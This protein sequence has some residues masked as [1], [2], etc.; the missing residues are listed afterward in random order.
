MEELQEQS[1]VS[2]AFRPLYRFYDGL[3]RLVQTRDETI[4]GAQQTVTQ[5]GYDALGRT[6]ST[7]VP[8]LASYVRG[9]VAPNWASAVQTNQAYDALGQVVRVTA[10]DG[11]HTD[12]MQA[13]LAD[14]TVDANGHFQTSF[15]DVFG[16]VTSVNETLT[17]LEDPFT[18][19]N[20]STWITNPA[21]LGCQVIDASGLKLTGSGN[22]NNTAVV[23][24]TAFN[25]DGSLQGQGVKFEFKVDGANNE[26]H[27][28]LDNNASGAAYQRVSILANSGKLTAR[29]F[30]SSTSST[31][32]DLASPL[33]ANVW[34]VG[35]LEVSSGGLA[36][37]EVWQRDAPSQHGQTSLSLA[38][39]QSYRFSATLFTGHAW[40]DNYQEFNTQTTS[41]RYDVLDHLV[42]V[43][44]ARGASTVIT[45]SLAGA[46]IGM[47][48]PNL[49]DWQY[50]YDG[51]GNLTQQVDAKNQNLCFY[52]DALNRLTGKYYNG[53][54]PTCPG[55]PSLTTG[56]SYDFGVNGKGRR[57]GLIDASGSAKWLYDSRGRVISETKTV[58][59][60]GTFLTKWSYDA[61]DRVAT[62]TYPGG[63]TGTAGEVVTNVYSN[64]ALL[65][66]VYGTSI[67]VNDTA[68]DAAGRIDF[69]QLGIS[70]STYAVGLDYVYNPWT[71]SGGRLQQI[72][73]GPPGTPTNLLNLSY[74]YDPAGNVL[75]IAD[76]NAS[77]TQTQSFTYDSLDRLITAAASGG[78]GGTYGTQTYTLDSVG[79]INATTA[80]GYY[81]YNALPTGCSAGS[82]A[83]RHLAVTN[84]GS[85]SY[86]YDC[87]GNVT[88]RTVGS[89]VYVL[90]Y[91]PENR[92][93]GVSGAATAN[94]LYDGDG[95]RVRATIG[96][97]TTTYLSNYYEWTGTAGVKYYYAGSER[98]AMR[99]AGGTL[100]F[101]LGDHL[102][103]TSKV[104]TAT[105]GLVSEL[106][107]GPWGDTRYSS[108]TTP[109]NFH[110]TGQRQDSGLG[111][112]YYYGARWY[113]PYLNRWLQPD[114]IV[115]GAGNPQALDRYT[116]SLNSPTNYT[117]PSGHSPCNDPMG[118]CQGG[119]GESTS[120]GCQA[121]CSGDGNGGNGGTSSTPSCNLSC[122]WYQSGLAEEASWWSNVIPSI[123]ILGMTMDP[124][125]AS[126]EFASITTLYHG[127]INNATSISEN[128]LDVNYPGATY[129]S[130]DIAVA[131]D[132]IYNR[133]E[134]EVTDPGLFTSNVPTDQ[135]RSLL[136]SK[137]II[138]RKGYLGF[139]GSG[140][141][142]VEYLLKTPLAKAFF[143]SGLF[144]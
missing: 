6:V 108:G 9:Y 92:L 100:Y 62:M 122:W 28:L 133:F 37:V 132:A 75:S 47:I 54:N 77:G 121:D 25:L 20:T 96:G 24:R 12:H 76:A 69:Q 118:T 90:S 111:G 34:Y 32:V 79:R 142:S 120:S 88:T 97:L 66:R 139:F 61:M 125:P 22:W 114:T 87:N 49:G 102:G 130:T 36:R 99:D 91:D 44:D 138:A 103:S 112:I 116:Y 68:Y 10:P 71:T 105:G 33:L 128:G 117:D 131:K 4:D 109:T 3:G 27:F 40:L 70:G 42:G 110:F 50:Q 65:D 48:D 67:Y 39:G 137:D 31:D 81:T 41:Y 26:A 8:A 30:T 135:F 89:S 136:L 38:S 124:G 19:I 106:R 80:L 129:V 72:K 86:G 127:S 57:T 35:V 21:C 73:A 51:S 11:T 119:G 64:S 85:Y 2:G 53:S 98:V 144:K 59:G 107:Y 7:T 43:T 83:R 113:D 56:Y 52:Y 82:Y 141:N 18:T 63:N 74:S 78:T 17:T 55:S 15:R 94:M 13:N 143:N 115:P 60:S 95:S 140:L 58:T 23:W 1:G 14:Y 123:V 134:H 46:K 84:A 104:A 45:Y 5:I 16:R 29:F 126:E 93:T 101:L